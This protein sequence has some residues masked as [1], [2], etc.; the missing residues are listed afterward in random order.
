MALKLDNIRNQDLNRKNQGLK[1]GN[2][3]A[4]S[5]KRDLIYNSEQI[6]REK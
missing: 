1:T 3:A 6:K 2:Q 5:K 4:S